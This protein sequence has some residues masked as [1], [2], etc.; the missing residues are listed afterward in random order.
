MTSD[1]RLRRVAVKYLSRLVRPHTERVKV[2][3]GVVSF[4][5]DDFPKSAFVTGG[6]ILESYGSRGTYY[7]CM[8]LAG[9]DGVSDR[10]FGPNDVREAHR[11]GHEI[12]CHTYSHIDCFAAPKTRV[13]ADTAKNAA[14]LE[15]LLG[16][17]TLANFAYPYAQPAVRAKLALA[18]QF[19]SCRGGQPGINAGSVDFGELRAN[20]IRHKRFDRSAARALIDQNAALGGWLIFF[21][22]DV[23]EKPS[24]FGCTPAE[25]EEVVAY[26]VTRSRLLPIQMA[27]DVLHPAS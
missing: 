7:V 6:R 15:S 20:E 9:T 8:A 3:G 14:A 21:T 5:F 1:G 4:T 11:R 19:R 24:E 22:H 16:P 2:D 23:I 13:L 18:K 26:A 17:V 25:L 12:A 10:M 27:I